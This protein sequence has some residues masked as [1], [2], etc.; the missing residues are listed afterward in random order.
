M[1]RRAGASPRYG[2]CGRTIP[3][4]LM[5]ESRATIVRHV[6]AMLGFKRAGAVGVRQRQSDPHPGARRRR[7]RRF[8]HPDLHRGLFASVVCPRHRAVPLDIARQRSRR[9][10]QDRRLSARRRFRTIASSPI[11]SRWRGSMCRSKVCQ[12]ASPGSDMASAPRLALAVNRMVREGAL[13]G[14]IAFTRDHLDAGA[15]A[16]PNIMTERMRDGSDAIADWPLLDAMAMCSSQAD[17]VAIHS[18]G[19]GYSGYMTSAGV[20]VIADGTSEAEQRSELGAD[21]RHQSW[22]HA[23]CR[24]R[25][26]GGHRRGPRQGH[27][28]LPIVLS[29]AGAHHGGPAIDRFQVV[30]WTT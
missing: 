22:R 10:P 27:Q 5:K 11:G 17:L 30:R 15:M 19:G 25:I 6:R 8:R 7:C 26:P 23:L 12:R 21:Q 13:S 2:A 3:D 29:R 16:H 28:S 1:C 24:R 14:P 9:H 4:A 18:G 20:T